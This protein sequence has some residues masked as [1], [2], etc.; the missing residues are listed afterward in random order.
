MHVPAEFERGVQGDD[1]QQA[2]VD[3]DMGRGPALKA[4]GTGAVAAL[5]YAEQHQPEDQDG[6]DGAE[7]I[8]E[9]GAAVGLEVDCGGSCQTLSADCQHAQADRQFQITTVAALG[10]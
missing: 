4:A 5:A 3:I 6:A 8:S 7:G 1:D 10:Q 9:P 2:G